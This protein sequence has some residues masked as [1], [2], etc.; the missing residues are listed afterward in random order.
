MVAGK[1]AKSR[2]LSDSSSKRVS[3]PK[4]GNHYF[5]QWLTDDRRVA[6]RF[7]E[8][9]SK[10]TMAKERPWPGRPWRPDVSGK[11]AE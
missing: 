1:F 6:H 10:L 2:P 11:K 5:K 9:L 7:F 3:A 8:A 4:A